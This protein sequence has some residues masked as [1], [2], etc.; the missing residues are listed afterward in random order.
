MRRWSLHIQPDQLTK[1]RYWGGWSNNRR[2]DY[3]SRCRKQLETQETSFATDDEPEL[4]SEF[5][6]LCEQCGSDRMELISESPKPSW[7]EL[8]WHEHKR[9]PSWYA[10]RQQSSHRQFWTACYGSDFYDWYIET[11]VESAKH[12]EPQLSS[13]IQLALPGISLR[14][15]SRVLSSRLFLADQPS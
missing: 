11:Q 5:A 3:L 10:Q 13:P 9:C 7:S 1:T 8:F 12:I 2:S 6:L 14:P 15:L 4:N